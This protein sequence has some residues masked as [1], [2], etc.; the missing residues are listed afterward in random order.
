MVV[1]TTCS[2]RNVLGVQWN[3]FRMYTSLLS[4]VDHL[5]DELRPISPDSH[6]FDQRDGNGPLLDLEGGKK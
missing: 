5:A 4:L 1:H 3:T 6:A 2:P